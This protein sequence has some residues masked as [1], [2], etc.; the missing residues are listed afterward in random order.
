MASILAFACWFLAALSL[1][2]ILALPGLAAAEPPGGGDESGNAVVQLP[3]AVAEAQQA[4]V[5]SA[6]ARTAV[7]YVDAAALAVAAGDLTQ[8]GRLLAQARQLLDQIQGGIR[9]RAGTE[10]V[11][12]IP[13]MAR[14][15]AA[16]GVEVSDALAARIQALEPQVLAGDHDRVLAALRDVGVSLTYDYVGMPVQATRD[17]IGRAEA[18][19]AAGESG[20]ALAA[21]TQVVRGLDARTLSIGPKGPEGE[22]QGTEVEPR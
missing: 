22:G 20:A 4:K 18:A 10:P 1:L 19:L 13:V 21:L 12:V 5:L 6:A 2:L 14:V 8:A 11:T 16:E 17:G 7:N 15:R 9:E 3:P